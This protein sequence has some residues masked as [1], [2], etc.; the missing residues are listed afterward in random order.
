MGLLTKIFTFL[1]C[2]NIG[3]TLIGLSVGGDNAISKFFNLGSDDMTVTG[4]K[5]DFNSTLPLNIETGTSS[6]TATF[7]FLDA[8]KMI[9][10]FIV[11]LFGFGLTPLYWFAIFGFPAWLTFLIGVPMALLYYL[12]LIIFLRGGQA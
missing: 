10:A 3:L 8:I 2:L 12:G 6:G 11:F 5:S 4:L 1:L 7:G 9:F